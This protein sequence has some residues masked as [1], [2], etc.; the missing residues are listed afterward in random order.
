M[1]GH[2]I[3]VKNPKSGSITADSVGEVIN[4]APVMECTGRVVIRDGGNK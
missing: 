1:Q 4:E 2:I 3:S